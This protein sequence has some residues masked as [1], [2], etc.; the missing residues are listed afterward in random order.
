VPDLLLYRK[1]AD[2]VSGLRDRTAVQERL[3]QLERVEEFL[4][5]WLEAG[6]SGSFSAAFTIFSTTAEFEQQLYDHL[7]ELLERRWGQYRGCRNP[8][9]PSAIP[10]PLALRVRPRAGVFRSKQKGE[11]RQRMATLR[12]RLGDHLVQ[13]DPAARVKFEDEP[14]FTRRLADYFPQLGIIRWEQ[15]IARI[16]RSE[17]DQ[18]RDLFEPVIKVAA[19]RCNNPSE[20][21]ARKSSDGSHKAI[22]LGRFERIERQQ[23]FKLV[24]HQYQPSG[25]LSGRPNCNWRNVSRP[26][27]RDGPPPRR[28]TGRVS[29][30]L[31]VCR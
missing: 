25:S 21:R 15:A 27:L 26:R 4:A 7:R 3:A 17:A 30:A 11:K 23:L 19:H 29:C 8:L 13:S 28:R 16:I 2:P 24:D 22:K 31:P 5:R 14:R 12:G 18:S 9:A 6:E 20:T 1:D 10:R